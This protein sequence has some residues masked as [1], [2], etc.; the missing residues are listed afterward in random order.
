MKVRVRSLAAGGAM[1]LALFAASPGV[2]LGTHEPPRLGLTPLGTDGPY[3]ELV[4]AGGQGAE[5]QVELANFGHA[6]VLARTYAA[7]AYS[8]VNGGFGA[9]LFGADASGAA[10][11]LSYEP[12]EATL[13][14]QDAVILDLRV[15][16]PVDTPPGEYIAALV[17]ENVEPYRDGEGSVAVDQVNRV[18]LAV[19]ID[20]PGPR[21]PELAIGSVSHAV[22]AGTSF[23]SFEV[24]NPGNV[25]LK[26]AGDFALRDADGD[27]LAAA[28]AVM[29]SVYAGSVTRFEAPLATALAPGEYC[30]E[31]SLADE[32]TGAS[33]TTECLPFT[34]AAA[35]TS[36]GAAG[37][38]AGAIPVIQPAIDAIAEPLV[39]ATVG[40]GLLAVA[41]AVWWLLAR[42]R[43]LRAE[44][45]GWLDAFGAVLA[46]HDEVSRAWI[47]PEDAGQVLVVEIAREVPPERGS[48]LAEMLGASLRQLAGPSGAVRLRFVQGTGPVARLEEGPAPPFYIR[49]GRGAPLPSGG[50]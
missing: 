40:L 18:A 17:A 8:I 30:A 43:R 11:W 47:V 33:A 44:P 35:A 50:A 28:P 1:A 15:D 36:P 14:P 37:A 4:L 24:T 46:H 42:R 2:A 26:P 48:Q 22:A 21:A 10:R 20:V 23:V 38:D 45:P 19:A 25:H 27:A 39:A 12:R 41:L 5:L 13:G 34:V 29:D 32:A 3:F 7:D 6:D 16:V 31:L 9:E 49:A